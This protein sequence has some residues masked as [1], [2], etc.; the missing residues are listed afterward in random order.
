MQTES[1]TREYNVWPTPAPPVCTALWEQE[2]WDRFADGYRPDD[3]EGG[4]YDQEAW[5]Q[6]LRD[7]EAR[8][9]W[10]LALHICECGPEHHSTSEDDY[11][12]TCL[13]CGGR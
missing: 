7:K 2:A 1:K 3:Y 11:G 12:P 6:H 5:E 8:K 13:A 10:W 4:R 9:K